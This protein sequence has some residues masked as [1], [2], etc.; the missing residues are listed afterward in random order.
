MPTSGSDAEPGTPDE[1][2]QAGGIVVGVDGS[3]TDADAAALARALEPWAGPP[4][5]AAVTPDGTRVAAEAA[6]P[7]DR[8][9]VDP[10]SV[11]A[12]LDRVAG[13]HGART[14]VVG[15]THR[16]KLGRVYPGSVG[17]RLLAAASVPVAVVP[18][19]YAERAEPRLYVIG[20]AFDGGEASMWAMHL[21]EAVCLKSADALRVYTAVPPAQRAPDAHTPDIRDQQ[22]TTRDKLLTALH[23]TVAEL[24]P[25][26]RALAVTLEG[27]PVASLTARSF[28]IDLLVAGAGVH[29]TTD[30]A[31]GASVSAELIESLACPVLVLPPRARPSLPA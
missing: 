21:A 24:D 8:P 28:E 12:E 23:T 19:G 2:E 31:L 22:A 16:G 4:L 3:E 15:S 29:G 10:R 9:D 26:A 25:A 20:V 13:E 11:A 18:R 6:P 14:I 17:R 27:D 5:F 1:P 30:I 7:H